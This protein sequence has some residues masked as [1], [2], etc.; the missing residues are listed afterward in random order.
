MQWKL[1]PGS[2]TLSSSDQRILFLISESQ[3][4]IIKKCGIRPREVVVDYYF[5]LFFF[6]S[7]AN[8][9]RSLESD[10]FHFIAE[11]PVSAPAAR[12]NLWARFTNWPVHV[13][14]WIQ[15]V[16][17]H[18]LGVSD[19]K[20]QVKID[21]HFWFKC[22]VWVD[23]W[24]QSRLGAPLCESSM[25]PLNLASLFRIVQE[26][27]GKGLEDELES[28]KAHTGAEEIAQPG[29]YLLYKP[30]SL[31]AGSRTQCG[32]SRVLWLTVVILAI[33]W[34]ISVTLW[35]ASPL[36]YLASR[37]PVKLPLL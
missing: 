11:G 34:W 24:V 36:A 22:S 28:R 19:R 8:P 32:K 6:P 20:I 4:I 37:R 17:M 12:M 26:S 9:K 29:K 31:S 5:F 21:V 30:E 15:L 3:I 18:Y 14:P 10:A 27:V 33:K 35:L 23:D 2:Q 7:D 25:F 1:Y 16:P 13:L